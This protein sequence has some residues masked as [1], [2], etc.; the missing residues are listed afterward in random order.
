MTHCPSVALRLVT[1]T[2]TPIAP[3][4]IRRRTIFERITDSRHLKV[5]TIIPILIASSAYAFGQ[6]LGKIFLIVLVYAVIRHH[7][8]RK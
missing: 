3:R 7:L 5:M 6:L 2:G 1:P 4:S 8:G